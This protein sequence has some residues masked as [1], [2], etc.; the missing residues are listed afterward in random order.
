M[1]EIRQRLKTLRMELLHRNLDAW[2]ISGTD[3]HASEYLPEM[4]QTRQYITGFTGSY[5]IVVVAQEE[6]ILWTDSRYF[7]Q[8]EEQ[9]KGSGIKMQKLRV[10]D[11]VP[12]ELWLAKK[13]TRG[14]KV[15][16]D[17][18]TLSLSSYRNLASTLERY[19]I[20][21]VE[22]PDLFEKVWENRPELPA[23]SVFELDSRLTGFSRKEKKDL[24]V[25]ELKKPDA[26]FQIITALDEL[27]WAFNL[28]GSDIAYNPLFIGYGV[29]GKNEWIL[30]TDPDKIPEHLKIQFEKEQISLLPYHSFFN[31]LKSNRGKKI[32]ID[33]TSAS[34]AVYS[35]IQSDNH[36]IE[37]LSLIGQL[38][39]QKNKTEL[40]GFREA[41]KKDGAALIE[42]LYWLKNGVKSKEIT[43]YTAGKKIAELR[44]EQKEYIGESFPPIVG[45][46]AHGA[47][48]HL[49]VNEEEAL[50]LEPE[51]ILLFDTG[52]QYLHGTTDITRTI[53]LGKPTQ[54]Q[55]TDYTLVLK[56]MINLTNVKFPT[57][58]KGTNI[59]V[60]ARIA[61]W[62][63]GLNYGHGTGHGVGH[64]LNV[65]E[66]PVSVR[67]DYNEVAL[68]PGVVLS[69]EPGLYRQ[70]QYG[71]R[72]E[73]LIVCVEKEETEFGR[74]LG[75]E[76][77]TLCP[78]DTSL[79]D[80]RLLTETE[81]KWLNEYHKKVRDTLKPLIRTEL[82]PFLEE[83]TNEI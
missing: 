43:E 45:Y 68:V 69:N 19:G 63:N 73:N 36:I 33:P 46:K 20:G 1:T 16:F 67:Q 18:Q 65:H 3:P 42:F 71:I 75:F 49:N 77:L 2:Y 9:L 56:G 60:L 22:T 4:W 15:G 38:K 58:T 25:S 64:F 10:P 40:D 47:I 17:P 53:A 35:S 41:M 76:T 74:F 78:I 30:F 72:I 50:V 7:I 31:W 44:A 70:N 13:L 23:T 11:A 34:Y 59:D 27:A 48:V 82:L 79:I 5:G 8:A 54:Q 80:V 62:Q 32:F 12:P 26:D 57:G 66:G 55:I 28:R 61:L 24:S 52:G 81:V 29:I 14:S 6:S 39:M 21:V 83:L 51:G 37:G